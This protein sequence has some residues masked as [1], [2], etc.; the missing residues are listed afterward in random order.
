MKLLSIVI[1]RWFHNNIELRIFEGNI[2]LKY[3]ISSSNSLLLLH[4]SKNDNGKYQ[5]MAINEAG[6][7]AIDLYLDINGKHSSIFFFSLLHSFFS[8]FFSF[9]FSTYFLNMINNNLLFSSVFFLSLLFFS[10]TS[11]MTSLYILI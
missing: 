9:F 1:F 8:F 5:C 3:R 11:F 6:Q 7:D 4:T 2:D 10:A